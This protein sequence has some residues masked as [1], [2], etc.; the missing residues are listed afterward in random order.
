M[1]FFHQYGSVGFDLV[2]RFLGPRFVSF[3]FNEKFKSF[4]S[5][6]LSYIVN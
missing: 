6:I 3:L 2:I 4:G 1:K 5:C